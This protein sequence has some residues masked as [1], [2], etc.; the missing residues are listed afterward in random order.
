MSNYYVCIQ[1][2]G[3]IKRMAA[4]SLEDAREVI[5]VF[6]VEES[7]SQHIWIVDSW[8]EDDNENRIE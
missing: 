1:D 7:Q 2:E 6:H 3:G 4:E 8:I 5:R